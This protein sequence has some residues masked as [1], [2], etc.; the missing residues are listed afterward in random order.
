MKY[1]QYCYEQVSSSAKYCSACG[2]AF[3][4]VATAAGSSTEVVAYNIKKSVYPLTKYVDNNGGKA[5]VSAQIG[6][7]K[8]SASY[9]RREGPKFS[10]TSYTP[11][12]SSGTVAKSSSS[13]SIGKLANTIKKSAEATIEQAKLG[14]GSVKVITQVDDVEVTTSYTPETNRTVTRYRIY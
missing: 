3:G 1:C 11:K 9:T 4:T 14:G 6:N 2:A 7:R 10:C 13:I 5:E 8:I 12:T